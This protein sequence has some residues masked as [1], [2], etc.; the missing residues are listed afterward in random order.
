MLYVIGS[1]NEVGNFQKLL[2][3]IS[4]HAYQREGKKKECGLVIRRSC[5]RACFPYQNK[6]M[7][8][9]ELKQIYYCMSL[10]RGPK[11]MALFG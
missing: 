8:L 10:W 11:N 4:L 7:A 9:T 3:S 2:Y 1:A 5:L 6:D